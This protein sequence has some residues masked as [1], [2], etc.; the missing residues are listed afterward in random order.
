MPELI[1]LVERLV[2]LP[3]YVLLLLV[4]VGGYKGWWV[5]GPTHR[6]RI[7]ALTRDR[8]EWRAIALDVSGMAKSVM[9]RLDGAHDA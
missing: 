6:E 9:A 7:D 1:A 4:L 8:D 2:S 3:L 5:Y